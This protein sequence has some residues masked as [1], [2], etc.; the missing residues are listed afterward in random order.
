ML[1]KLLAGAALALALGIVPASAE[2]TV[3]MLHVNQTGDPFW[4][5]V[6]EDYNK[7]HPGVKVVVEYMEN[8]AYK[9]KLPTLL[10]S[11]ERP[12]IIYSW[13]GGVMKAQIAAGYIEDITASKADFDKTIY[14]AP[15]GAYIVDG[16][17]YGIPLQLSEV[18]LI[19]NKDLLVKAGVDIKT[20]ATWEG[21]LAGVKKI[22]AAGI[23]PL[24]MGGGDKWPMH[25]IWSYLL[26]RQGGSDVL[27]AAQAT[28]KTGFKAQA[29]VDAGARLK[30]LAALEPFQNGWLDTKYLASQG[31]FGDGKAAMAVQLNGFMQGQQKNATDGKGIAD[32]KLGEAPFPTLPGGKG[33]VTDTLG[34]IQG[35]LVT[36]GSPKEAVDFLK[37]FALAEQHKAAAEAGVYVPAV[38]GT[39]AFIKNP[40]VA[41]VA[42][43]IANSTWHQN[44]LDQELGPSVGR[45]VNDISVA[46]AANSIKPE[47]GAAQTQEA[48]D[49]Q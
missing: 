14:S 34:G 26:M 21:F 23:T 42:R 38:K 33:K 22:N 47:E 39:D 17:L 9:A 8:E 35:F 44:F 24:S 46:I 31:V 45:V 36:K 6:A 15:M 43:S 30:E 37:F 32:D 10:Q 25:F 13:A 19:Y 2:V 7:A 3:R 1:K 11:N 20:M 49:Q 28:K 18:L 4:K 29:F 48:W 40:L 5:K 16:K 27:S 12:N 41:E